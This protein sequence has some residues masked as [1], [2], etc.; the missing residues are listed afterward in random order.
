MSAP[1]LAIIGASV[2]AAACS[3]L[4]GG[5]TPAG[6]D[7]FGDVDLCARCQVLRANKYPQDLAPLAARLPAGPWMYTGALENHPEV[8]D[9]IS[10]DRPLWGNT[11]DVVRQVRSPERLAE[12]LAGSGWQFPAWQR[13]SPYGKPGDWLV[14]ADRSAGGVQVQRWH[15]GQAGHVQR[16][17]WYYQ[18]HVSGLPCAAVYVAAQREAQLLGVSEQLIGTAW[19]GASD[20]RYAGSLGPLAL[21]DDCRRQ[22]AQLGDCLAAEFDL[23]GL[24]GVDLVLAADARWVIEVNPR[25]TASMEVL[26]RAGDFSAVAC[27]AAACRDGVLPVGP[28]YADTWH[29]KVVLYARKDVAAQRDFV[30]RALQANRQRPW[31]LVA[32]IPWP[33]SRLHRGWPIVTLLD[34]APSRAA[35][36]ERLQRQSADWQQCL[37]SASGLL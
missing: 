31:P 6:V 14:K 25:Y 2:R 1:R 10:R 19:T 11:A 21:T 35:L 12:R 8:I 29:G 3:A 27:H 9:T 34:E 30:E 36:I 23:V 26:E 18:Q 16:P 37:Y 20:F 7:L 24:F 4:S 22:L 13:A 15:E 5:F 32:D 17:G 28:R 33:A